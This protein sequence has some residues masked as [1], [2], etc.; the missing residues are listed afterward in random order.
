L[1]RYASSLARLVGLGRALYFLISL[2]MAILRCVVYVEIMPQI[3]P[4][5][6]GFYPWPL[7]IVN[8]R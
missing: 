4:V 5:G 3:G 1:R 2:V 8:R 6:K 7:D